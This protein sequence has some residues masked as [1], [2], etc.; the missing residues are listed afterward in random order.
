MNK[1][2]LSIFILSVLSFTLIMGGCNSGNSNT[3]ETTATEATAEKQISTDSTTV[4]ETYFAKA[5]EGDNPLYGTW[6]IENFDYISFVFRNDDLAEL[7][8]GTEGS[9]SELT[10]DEEAKT[11]KTSFL[12]GLQGTYNYVLSEDENTLTLSAE[13][14]TTETVLN[15]QQAYD[16]IPE[17]P[18]N[19]VVDED[20][21]GWWKGDTGLIYYFGSDGIMYSNIITSETCYTYEAQNG[22]INAVYDCGGETNYDVEYEYKDGTLTI[23][24]NEYTTFDPF[25][26]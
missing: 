2:I 7:A 4:L 23:D 11:L 10:I 18:K 20:I 1:K 8:M 22:Q 24:G 14:S 16:F 3:V 6:T 21:L 25:E 17:A 5:V 13:N 9:F 12:V 19:A 26:E 15:R